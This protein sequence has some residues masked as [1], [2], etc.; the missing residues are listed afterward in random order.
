MAAKTFL[1][2]ALSTGPVGVLE[3][4]IARN[5]VVTEEGMREA[6]SAVAWRCAATFG[7][8]RNPQRPV[9]DVKAM[10]ISGL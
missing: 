5:S 3:D 7:R 6:S 2:A 1:R 4:T 9:N 8:G 10:A